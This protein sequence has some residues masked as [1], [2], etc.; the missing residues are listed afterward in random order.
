[1]FGSKTPFEEVEKRGGEIWRF[2]RRVQYTLFVGHS[3]T[4]KGINIAV[5]IPQTKFAYLFFFLEFFLS[6]EMFLK[7]FPCSWMPGTRS[8]GR[9]SVAAGSA[10]Q[11]QAWSEAFCCCLFGGSL[12]SPLFF[13]RLFFVTLFPSGGRYLLRIGRSGTQQKTAQ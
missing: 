6:L 7:N 10:S 13:S 1:M 11:N 12:L 3:Q 8:P 5:R 2:E 4:A 9:R